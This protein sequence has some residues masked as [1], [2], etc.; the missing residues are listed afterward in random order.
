M[1]QFDIKREQVKM[2]RDMK[3]NLGAQ[4]E[5]AIVFNK[6]DLKYTPPYKETLTVD[7]FEKHR[8]KNRMK[9]Q[10]S[11]KDEIH[12]SCMDPDPPKSLDELKNL[13]VLGYDDLMPIF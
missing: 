9:F 7:Y 5:V 3:D 10:C 2:Y 1:W 6:V 8:A 13:D 12:F 11:D 4:T